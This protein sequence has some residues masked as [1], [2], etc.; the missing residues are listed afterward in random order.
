MSTD[1]NHSQNGKSADQSD[2][3]SS[4]AAS[5]QGSAQQASAADWD[6]TVQE[7]EAERREIKPGQSQGNNSD[8]HNNGRGGGK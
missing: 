6:Q 5:Q 4:N 1:K 2:S 7:A 8:Q 3:R